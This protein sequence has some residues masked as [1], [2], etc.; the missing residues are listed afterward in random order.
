MVAVII[1]SGQPAPWPLAVGQEGLSVPT[2]LSTFLLL[3]SPGPD[4]H[5][6]TLVP[7]LLA[8][9]AGRAPISAP[10]LLHCLSWGHGFLLTSGMGGPLP[11]ASLDLEGN[12]LMGTEPAFCPTSPGLR[13]VSEG[14]GRGGYLGHKS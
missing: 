9:D 13:W 12:K 2:V 8:L 11:W 7:Q 14:N 1:T 4:S 10:R 5:N 6:L 3:F